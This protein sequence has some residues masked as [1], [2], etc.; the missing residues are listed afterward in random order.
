[1]VEATDYSTNHRRPRV[2]III[3]EETR[4]K[5]IETYLY[6]ATAWTKAL[7]RFLGQQVRQGEN[8]LLNELSDR[9]EHAAVGYG[10]LANRLSNSIAFMVEQAAT[11]IRQAPVDDPFIY[12]DLYVP[13]KGVLV[14]QS[15][16]RSE[17]LNREQKEAVER[18]RQ[19]P[20]DDPEELII[21]IW[22]PGCIDPWHV[23]AAQL[24]TPFRD[25]FTVAMND[26]LTAVS[27][28]QAG[29][30]A[31][32]IDGPVNRGDVREKL[33]Y[34]RLTRAPKGS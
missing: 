15:A 14:A 5:A 27:R 9:Q 16:T 10:Q 29:E 3:G 12:R 24:L 18:A 28:V 13:A 31:F 2:A 4:R 21:P 26:V 33:R 22:T 20:W 7:N 25:N 34:W 30:P 11:Y 8:S 23:M 19:R 17:Q 32:P 1:M 6:V